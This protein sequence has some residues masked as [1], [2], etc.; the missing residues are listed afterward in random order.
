MQEFYFMK[1]IIAAIRNSRLARWLPALLIM[2]IIFW[3]SSRPNSSLPSFDWADVIVK[4]SG[5]MVGYALL[6]LSYWH[7]FDFN[8]ENRWSAWLLAILYAATDE[9]H[10]SF[11]VGRHPS[12]WDVLIFD[13]LG[14]LI[15][16]WLATLYI[17]RK[18]PDHT[19]LVVEKPKL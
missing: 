6:A 5:H 19:N 15:S 9:F 4:K 11:T 13:N 1:L 3:F 17:K 12:A 8:R 2:L 7:A 14:A 18:Q 10:Q 16:L